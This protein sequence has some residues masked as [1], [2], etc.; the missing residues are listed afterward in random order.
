MPFFLKVP[1]G[2]EPHNEGK[3]IWVAKILIARKL[4]DSLFWNS[5]PQQVLFIL[6]L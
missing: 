6:K 1:L 3:S 2:D 4:Q 5:G